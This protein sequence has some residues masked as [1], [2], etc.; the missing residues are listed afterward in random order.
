MIDKSFFVNVKMIKYE[1]SYCEPHFNGNAYLIKIMKTMK[2]KYFLPTE[3]ISKIIISKKGNQM[4]LFDFII[5]LI[6]NKENDLM[7]KIINDKYIIFENILYNI[8][9]VKDINN[10]FNYKDKRYSIN[11]QQNKEI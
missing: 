7:D 6:C 2:S 8:N 1:H 9:I 5:T 4:S 11:V 3:I 10:I